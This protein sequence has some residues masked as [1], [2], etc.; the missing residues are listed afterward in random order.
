MHLWKIKNQEYHRSWVSECCLMLNKQL[1]SD[2]KTICIKKNQDTEALNSKRK[3]QNMVK[4]KIAIMIK[5]Q[6]SVLI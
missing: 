5:M 4:R 3:L 1:K 6:L 2:F